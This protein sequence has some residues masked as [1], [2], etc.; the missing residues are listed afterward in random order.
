MENGYGGPVWHASAMIHN[1][2]DVKV[3]MAALDGVG[4]SALGEWRESGHAYH[5]KR[6]LSVAEVLES[7]LVMTDFRNTEI[8]I[9]RVRRHLLQFPQFKEWAVHI[10]E[11]TP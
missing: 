4:D 1:R 10:G 11:W 7:G 8:G 2:P 9:A 3:A 6:R 5:I